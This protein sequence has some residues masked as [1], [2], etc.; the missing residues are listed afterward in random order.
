MLKDEGL[1]NLAKEML[2]MTEEDMAKVTRGMEREMK[3]VVAALG[4]YRLVAEV[5]HSKYCFAALEPGQKFVV[6][7]DGKLDPENTTA[8]LCLGAVGPLAEKAR[9]M[10][11]RISQNGDVTAPMAGFRCVD[12]G[13]DLG[14]LGSVDFEVR[15]EKIG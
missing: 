4:K 9:I 12:P 8:P 10:M 3:N 13:L 7:L 6:E 15:I 14:G 11:D 2:G 1:R 5:V